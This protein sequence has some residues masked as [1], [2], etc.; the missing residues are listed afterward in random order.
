MAQED[1]D[2]VSYLKA[3]GH[4]VGPSA[5]TALP[6]QEPAGEAGSVAS[7]PLAGLERRRS[8]RYKC[9]G[10]VEMREE[11]HDV[12]TYAGFKDISFHGCY[13][14][15]TATH[16]VGTVLNLKLEANGFEVLARGIVRVNYPALGMGI[17]L[18]E[19]TEDDRTRLRQLLR[20]ISRKAIVMG[21]PL[22]ASGPIEP[23]PLLTDPSAALRAVVEFFEKRQ[24]LPREE[25]LRILRASQELAAKAGQ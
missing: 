20:T 4:T 12:R 17:A 19:M 10:S 14:E 23:V 15:A 7:Q 6:A 18:T 1:N 25:F 21:A 16:P 8:P 13:V 2:G 3:L 24:S 22:L 11:G 9:Q 5:A